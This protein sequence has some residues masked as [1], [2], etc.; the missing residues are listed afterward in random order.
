MTHPE[1]AE[2]A[3]ALA[4]GLQEIF[5]G[6]VM[7]DIS[8]LPPLAEPPRLLPAQLTSSI[9]LGGAIRGALALHC[10]RAVALSIAGAMLGIEV[11]ELDAD[12]Q[13][14]IGEIANMLAGHLKIALAA[15]G[16]AVH[17]AVPTTVTGAGYRIGGVG[18][19]ARLVAPFHIAAGEFWVE[20]LIAW[21]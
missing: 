8:A 9:G 15:A 1:A 16:I 17:L 7:L 2:L 21:G 6:M 5:V 19:A 13:D 14:A 3:V 18:G 12:T 11:E 10:P 20:L 4:A